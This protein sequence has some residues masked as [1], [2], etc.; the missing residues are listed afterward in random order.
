M[1]HDLSQQYSVIDQY[2]A[3]IRDKDIQRDAFRFRKNAERLAMLMGYEISKNLAWQEKDVQTPLATAKTHQ[4]QEQPVL[5]T[6]LR[7]GLIMHDG[8]LNIFDQGDNAF[9]SCYR[10]AR[11]DSFE[12]QLE[13]ITC[14]SLENRVLIISDPMLATGSSMVKTLEQ[15]LDYGKPSTVHIAVLVASEEGIAYVEER[16]P[17]AHIWAAAIDP[18][19]DENAYIVPGLGDAGDLA[20][21]TK[22]QE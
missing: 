5:A 21:G 18:E 22:I 9:I 12:I 8:L 20:Y 4:L 19:L 14:P 15:L 17:E 2:I 7:A 3:E 1:L 6:I 16:L 10:K 13:Y 11:A